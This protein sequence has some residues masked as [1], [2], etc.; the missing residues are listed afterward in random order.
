V[1]I[2]AEYGLSA[3]DAVADRIQ[4]A[5]FILMQ[6][7]TRRSKLCKL[8]NRRIVEP[9]KRP[10]Y[11]QMDC[12]VKPEALIWLIG[13][14]LWNDFRKIAKDVFRDCGMARS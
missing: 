8:D 10:K 11:R 2:H 9:V 3:Y 12:P 1:R 4:G 7:Q 6:P 5:A 13:R 14:I